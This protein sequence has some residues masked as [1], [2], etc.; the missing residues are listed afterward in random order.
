VT[1]QEPTTR[2]ARPARVRREADAPVDLT[3]LEALY[4]VGM[5]TPREAQ[6]RV[7]SVDALVRARL[8]YPAVTELGTLYALDTLGFRALGMSVKALPSIHRLTDVTYVRLALR[9]FRWTLVQAS[10]TLGA[11]S[12]YPSLTRVRADGFVRPLI[13]TVTAGGYRSGTLRSILKRCKGNLLHDNT[14]LLVLHPNPRHL[15]RVKSD[16]PDL[17]EVVPF[18][19]DSATL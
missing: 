10:S 5:W 9:E 1:R 11:G 19:P 8:I 18:N 12:N 13:G 4:E 3:A 7:G 15:S 2:R 16:F 17:I 14:Q 6:E